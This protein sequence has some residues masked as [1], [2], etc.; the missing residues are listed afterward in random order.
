M[1][2]AWLLALYLS[3]PVTPAQ[4][5][6]R[7]ALAIGLDVSGSVDSREYALQSRGLANALR[8]PDVTAALLAM[9]AA[10]VELAVYEWSGP[11]YQKQV[12]GWTAITDQAALDGVTA[13]LDAAHRADAPPVTGLGRAMEFGAALLQQRN[14]CWKLTLDISGDGRS[15]SGL[16]PDQAKKRLAHLPMT[17][18]ALV[19]GSDA[20][21]GGDLR[22][23][24]IGEL[25]SYFTA[26]VIFGPDAFVETALGFE[27][28]EVAMVRKL[29]K[30]LTGL[31]V[32]SLSPNPA[33]P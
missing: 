15:N 11:E 14:A 9:P 21:T 31:A 18:N 23:V 25:S 8:H 28:Y 29:K 26:Y 7:Q 4:A 3:A 19:I 30:E 20:D 13:R 1:K 6:G 17:L 5:E 10:P 22:Q 12:V 16:R 27:Q 32:S 33:R 24:E 2:P